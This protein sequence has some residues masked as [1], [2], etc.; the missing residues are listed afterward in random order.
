R[1]QLRTLTTQ[2][3]ETRV[4]LWLVPTT[5]KLRGHGL[6]RKL[7]GLTARA[8]ETSGNALAPN[9]LWFVNAPGVEM[10]PKGFCVKSLQQISPTCVL[11]ARWKDC[12][13]AAGAG[14]NSMLSSSRNSRT[15]PFRI[16]G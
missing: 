7:G 13:K 11:A 5:S 8:T 3:H 15:K 16:F 9:S 4:S 14:K 2:S 6:L 1:R 10:L 12:W